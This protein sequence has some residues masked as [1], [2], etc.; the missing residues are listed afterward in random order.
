MVGFDVEVIDAWLP[1]VTAVTPP[2]VWR[3]L[4]GGHSNLTYE[5]TDATGRQLVIRR[6][7]EGSI[8]V[9]PERHRL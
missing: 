7:P 4:P 8:V 5:L 1:T 6:P 3:R 9:T 2:I